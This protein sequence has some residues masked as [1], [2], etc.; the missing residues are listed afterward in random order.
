MG[1]GQIVNTLFFPL[2]IKKKNSL[3]NKQAQTPSPTQSRPA[4]LDIKCQP[5]THVTRYVRIGTI[6]RQ[7]LAIPL[8]PPVPGSIYSFLV[9]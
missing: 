9:G 3:K 7:V 6:S 8:D 4:L 2:T 1:I 5:L